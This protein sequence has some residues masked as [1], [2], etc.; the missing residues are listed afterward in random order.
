[1]EMIGLSVRLDDQTRHALE[2]AA[3]RDDRKTRALARLLIREG[4]ARRGYL[5]TEHGDDRMIAG[6]QGVG[7]DH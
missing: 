7:H 3:Q 1:M 6:G 4:L 5:L 2:A